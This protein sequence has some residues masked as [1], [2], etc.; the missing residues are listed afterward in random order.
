M[1]E[2]DNVNHNFAKPA[3]AVQVWVGEYVLRQGAE[4]VGKLYVEELAGPADTKEHWL[5]YRNYRWPSS[6]YPN[7]EIS[8]HYQNVTGRLSDFLASPPEGS[9]YVIARCEQATLP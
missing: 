4:I 6:T 2:R 8:F 9:I 1:A 7:Q 3:D 5:L